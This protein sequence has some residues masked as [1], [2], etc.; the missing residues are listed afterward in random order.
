M[1]TQIVEKQIPKVTTEAVEKIQQVP[2]VLINEVGLDVPQVQTVEVFKQTA[3]ATSQ[4]IVQTGVQY[5]R[6]VGREVIERV[7]QGTMAGIYDAGVVGVRENVS[8]QPT[9]VERVSPVMTMGAVETF[10]A[11]TVV[12]TFGAPTVVETFGAPTVVATEMLAAPTVYET[13]AAP[14]VMEVVG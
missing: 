13:L 11:P 8:V 2:A 7:E 9:V 4:R 5:E 3:N 1:G 10:A 12:E 6:A 14:T